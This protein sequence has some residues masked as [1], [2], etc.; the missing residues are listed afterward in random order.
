MTTATQPEM[1]GFKTEQVVPPAKINRFFSGGQRSDLLDQVLHLTRFGSLTINVCGDTGTGKTHLLHALKSSLP[2]NAVEVQASLLM[3]ASELLNQ[4]LHQLMANRFHH[5]LPD[6]PA[7]SDEESLFSLISSYLLRL[8]DSGS[9]VVFLIDDAHEISE[10]G[11]RALFRVVQDKKHSDSVKCVLF[12]EP[13]IEKHLSNPS[14]KDSGGEQVFT[15]KMPSVDQE[16]LS[17]YL[18][19]LEA[20]KPESERIMYSGSDISMIHQLSEGRLG[21]VNAAIRSLLEK[22][23]PSVRRQSSFMPIY[24]YVVIGLV[25]LVLGGVIFFYQSEKEAEE[26]F[27]IEGKVLAPEVTEIRS[28]DSAP[29]RVGDDSVDSI[30]TESAPTA[31][32]SLLEQLRKK[33]EELLA[34]REIIPVQNDPVKE[35]SAQSVQQS[36]PEVSATTTDIVESI[37]SVSSDDIQSEQN[38]VSSPKISNAVMTEGNGS[39]QWISAQPGN[40]YTIQ[41]LG[42]HSQKNVERYVDG[43]KGDTQK[44]YI[45]E[46]VLR[47]Q[48]WFVLIYGSYENRQEAKKAGEELGLK[49]LW[50][51]DFSAIQ[52]EMVR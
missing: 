7:T 25:I 24:Q 48:P 5:D 28:D 2:G 40:H 33:Q 36:E 10:E 21:Q 47:G 26:T 45:Y 22:E 49:D 23:S 46:G 16:V 29:D 41:I 42:A 19:F 6:F 3:S 39:M 4:L 35:G 9:T 15:L 1:T 34:Q 52:K 13:Y 50:V 12:S 17:E 51:R 31:S 32:S 11:L 38:V 44:L 8:S 18:Q 37:E 20:V 14:V 27:S 43:F 30:S